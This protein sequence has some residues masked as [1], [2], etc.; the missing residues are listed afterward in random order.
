MQ[1]RVQRYGWDAAAKFYDDAWRKNLAPAHEAM[2]ALADLKP[3]ANAL[4]MACGSGL[5]T[6]RAAEI[7]GPEGSITA[8]DIS[9]AMVNQVRARASAWRRGNIRAYR[10]EALDLPDGNFDVALCALGLMYVPDP[11]QGLREMFRILK[12]GGQAVVAVWG[13]RSECA[14]SSIFPIV[15]SVV[16]SD[17][18]PLF[19]ELG[20]GDSLAA[21][22]QAAGFSSVSAQRLRASIDFDNEHDL[23][24]AMLDGGAVA[25]AAKR[26]DAA[27]RAN[28]AAEFMA[29]VAAFRRQDGSYAMPGAFVVMTARKDSARKMPG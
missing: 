8:T 14:W 10:A 13:E 1:R 9:E 12:P 27:T 3:G 18:C 6:F 19:F 24:T 17:V 4:D 11:L 5:L 7:V 16:Q 21:A 26:F 28:V 2:F 22:A 20:T 23:M 15:D 29:S 25:L